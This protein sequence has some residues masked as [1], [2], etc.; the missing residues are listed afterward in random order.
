MSHS[1]K[2]KVGRAELAE[3][4]HADVSTTDNLTVSLSSCPPPPAVLLLPF[5]SLPSS[6]HILLPSP[7][8]AMPNCQPS[9]LAVG[10]HIVRSAVPHSPFIS[11]KLLCPCLAPS[12]SP[13][14][15]H[16]I[17]AV[18]PS[19]P[20]LPFSLPACPCH[21]SGPWLSPSPSLHLPP[22]LLPL[23]LPLPFTSA[24]YPSLPHLHANSLPGPSLANALCPPSPHLPHLPPPPA[25]QL[26]LPSTSTSHHTLP[27]LCTIS[28]P[29]P[30]LATSLC[31]PPLPLPPFPLPPWP[32][33]FHL[34]LP[35][36]SASHPC[37][38]HLCAIS[39][40]GPSLFPP[41]S[42][43]PSAPCF[44]HLF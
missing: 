40:P 30:S 13:L 28:P 23:C 12:P 29:G 24:S 39:L 26:P 16:L 32:L 15:S 4:W 27:H 35:S 3:D 21:L 1:W 18:S 17:L 2:W 22:W 34:P 10:H 36:T 41:P 6:S 37:I 25:H 33:P 11:M 42:P 20:C 14:P 19:P 5:S 38:P 8:K 9:G 43:S 31:N 44:L 7:A